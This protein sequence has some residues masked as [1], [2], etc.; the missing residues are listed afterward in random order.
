L[1]S[2]GSEKTAEEAAHSKTKAQGRRHPEAS[3]D[4]HKNS[5]I[6]INPE[7]KGGGEVEP[8]KFARKMVQGK[9]TI[10]H[11]G[12]GAKMEVSYFCVSVC[13]WECIYI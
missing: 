1:L 8:V 10:D 5:S 12:T 3:H 11:L 6:M 13:V 2:G 4:A 7:A 9:N